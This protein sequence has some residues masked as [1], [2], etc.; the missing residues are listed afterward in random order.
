MSGILA[1]LLVLVS[2]FVVGGKP[3]EIPPFI[4]DEI[5]QRGNHV[6][7]LVRDLPDESNQPDNEK[8]PAYNAKSEKEMPSVLPENAI[9]NSR[10]LSTVSPTPE[11]N[12]IKA[13]QN[14]VNSA[15]SNPGVIINIPEGNPSEDQDLSLGK[16][17]APV[18]SESAPPPGYTE[19]ISDSP[20]VPNPGDYK[21]LEIHGPNGIITV[22]N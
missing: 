3:V 1:S 5:S 15:V 17:D 19:N 13:N 12:N 18:F 6:S 2:S 22:S 9:Q 21:P 7:D 14:Q 4:A 20:S 11:L 8:V 10:A 16:Y